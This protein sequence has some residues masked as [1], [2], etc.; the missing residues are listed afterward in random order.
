MSKLLIILLFLGLFSSCTNTKKTNDSTIEEPSV[1]GDSVSIVLQI[2]PEF[3]EVIDYGNG[4]LNINNHGYLYFQTEDGTIIS[5]LYN[6]IN[7]PNEIKI[8]SEYLEQDIYYAFATNVKNIYQGE[9]SNFSSIYFNKIHLQNN[10]QLIINKYGERRYEPTS[11]NRVKKV[12]S[13]EKVI[14]IPNKYFLAN[15]SSSLSSYIDI[16]EK[17]Y[18][19]NRKSFTIKMYENNYYNTSILSEKV[20][21]QNDEYSSDVSFVVIPDS[22]DEDTIF[23]NEEE[24]QPILQTLDWDES[25]N[26]SSEYYHFFSSVTIDND[27]LY[28]PMTFYYGNFPNH[29]KKLNYFPKVF[30]Q[31]LSN[32]Q[33]GIEHHIQTSVEIKSHLQVE[34]KLPINLESKDFSSHFDFNEKNYQFYLNSNNINCNFYYLSI[35]YKDQLINNIVYH[36]NYSYYSDIPI[37][38]VKFS[39]HNDLNKLNEFNIDDKTIELK[40]FSGGYSSYFQYDI[41]RYE[42][43]QI[44]N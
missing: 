2:A 40:R 11:N 3:F 12:T 39:F 31:D 44:T 37:E 33:F 24:I 27:T 15:W 38:F 21:F 35:K 14:V 9:E 32:Q 41:K 6:C 28:I 19:K 25:D 23:I 8:S 4:D 22:Y 34:N 43:S 1:N 18:D 10:Y 29:V 20:S 7:E 26:V 5:E 30:I 42:Y 13:I 36:F 17:S 16:N